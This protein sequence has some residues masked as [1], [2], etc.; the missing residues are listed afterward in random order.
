MSGLTLPDS[1]HRWLGSSPW[2]ALIL[3]GGLALVLLLI[4][5]GLWLCFGRGP[6]RRRAYKRVRQLIHQGAWQEA[7]AEVQALQR[8]GRLSPAWQGRV[9]NA[10]GECHRVAGDLALQE[11]RYE[12]SREHYLTSAHRLSLDE[13]T[14]HDRVLS[15]MLEEV[16]RLFASTLGPETEPVHKL[17]GRVLALEATSAEALFWQ[18]LCHVR[19]GNLEGATTALQAARESIG[20]RILEPSLYLGALLLS[21]GRPQEALR[22]LA[23]ANRQFGDCPFVTW[24]L[25]L[26]MVAKDALAAAPSTEAKSELNLGMRALQRAL[27]A[28]GLGQWVKAPQRAWVE[29]LPAAPR[30][31]VRRLVANYPFACPVLG[32]DVA[33]MVR[34]GQIALAQAHYRTGNFQEAANLYATVLREHAPSVP[35]L[36]GLGLALARLGQYD[37]AFIHLRTAHERE[38]PK[39]HLTAG[40][41][42]VCAAKGKPARPEDKPNNIV[43][44]IGLL[45]GFPAAADAEWAKIY[46]TIFAEARSAGVCVTAADQVRL[47]DVL[48]AVDATDPAAAEAYDHLAATFPEAVRAEYAWLYCRAALQHGTRGERDLEL[49]DR[50]FREQPAAQAFYEARRWDIEEIEFTYLERRATRQ[51]GRFPDTLGPDYA[52]RGEALLLARSRRQEEAGQKDAALATA[53]VLLKL[54]PRSPAAHD[55]LA[56]LV[57][58]RGDLDRAATLLSDSHTLAS[59]DYW[60]LVRQAVIERQRGRTAAANTVIDRALELTRGPVRAAVAFL[61]ARLALGINAECGVRSAECGGAEILNSELPTPNYERALYLLGQCLKE[62]PTHLRALS[63]LAA[64]RT[65]TGDTEGLARQA[66]SMHRTEVQDPRFHF[67]GAVCQLAARHY[68]LVIEAATRAAADGSL[69]VDSAYLMG[70][71]F[72]HQENLTGA[73]LALQKVANAA[74]SSSAD[75]AKAL[76]GRIGFARGVYDDAIRWWQALGAKKRA[77]WKFDG[78]LRGAVWLS[79]LTAFQ[80]G[81]FDQAAQ[82]LREAGRLGHRDSRLAPLLTLALVKAGQHQL[83]QNGA[84][85]TDAT[86]AASKD[87]PGRPAK[88]ADAASTRF[89]TAAR[90]LDQALQAGCKDPAVVYLLAMAHKRRGNLR[91]ARNALRKIEPADGNVWLQLGLL[92]RQEVKGTLTQPL[93]QAE[94]E[95]SQAWQED[96]AS[97]EACHNLLLTRLSLGQVE[98]AATL[99][100]RLQALAPAPQEQHRLA[101]LQALLPG[102]KAANGESSSNPLLT[103]MQPAD[104]QQL[105]KLTRGLGHLDTVSSLLRALAAARPGSAPVLEAYLEAILVQA[106]VLLDRYD[107]TA[108]DQLLAHFTRVKWASRP[109]MTALLNLLGCCACLAQDFDAGVQHFTSALR[110]SGNDARIHQ[111]LALAYEWKRQLAQ[112]DPHWNHFF[113]MLTNRLPVPTGWPDYVERLAYEGLSRVAAC[114]SEKERWADALAYVERAHQVRPKEADTLER[115]FHLYLQV[116]RPQDARQALRKLRELRPNEPQHDLYE[117]NLMKV[118]TLD[119]LER[120]LTELDRILKK[121][122]NDPRVQ[123]KAVEETGNVIGLMGNLY[124]QLTEQLGRVVN[125]VRHLPNSQINWSAVSEVMRDMRAEFQKLRRI[126]AKCMLLAVTEEQ[127]RVIREL[128]GRID[129]KIEVCRSWGG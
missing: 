14:A 71:A 28:K 125:Q 77:A 84:I 30:S 50:T 56:N 101:L 38:E 74:A 23:E 3:Y 113:E 126:T 122:P 105:L 46:S 104:E 57:Y 16:R 129:R 90:L 62:D 78:A 72:W 91:E 55:H 69:A 80:A 53:E 87:A 118:K 34:Q 70:W 33:A 65:V 108:A 94:Q 15:A 22:Y 12:E 19:D 67:L 7:L 95:F 107:W 40:W 47:C 61:G 93:H 124:D 51:P 29:G 92:S 24:Q 37:Q 43:W 9:R 120:K 60:P 98:E 97:Y 32:S 64:V 42:A 8:L 119:D 59:H 49:F 2:T 82:H 6:R 73:S 116:N 117:L 76:L 112:A 54:A 81:R 1:L 100:P 4:V 128:S 88:P 63:C 127:R 10:E 85:P 102:P 103:D 26:A 89:D 75:H 17:L 11:R 83:Y 110:L 99:I 5:V 123:D 114:Y 36:R 21:Q 27:G 106:K 109:A 111:N 41:L 52:Q 115:L 13:A 58:H 25:G 18:A 96:P 48:A 44:A 86:G 39:S 68:P 121:Y 66:S 45:A 31:F 79:A 20:N 35:V